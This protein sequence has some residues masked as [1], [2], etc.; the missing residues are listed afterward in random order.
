MSAPLSPN[1][2]LSAAVAIA[3]ISVTAVGAGAVGAAASPSA[4]P[5]ISLLD[6]KTFVTQS[7]EKGK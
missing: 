2:N 6:G 4:V 3:L 5:T 7:G 1:F